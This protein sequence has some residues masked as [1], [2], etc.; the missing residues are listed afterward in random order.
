[1]DRKYVKRGFMLALAAAFVLVAVSLATRPMFDAAQL[2]NADQRQL[3]QDV[4][5]LDGYVFTR[6][7]TSGAEMWSPTQIAKNL[8]GHPHTLE[9]ARR[10]LA[11]ASG[12]VKH[13]LRLGWTLAVFGVFAFWFGMLTMF[14]LGRAAHHVGART[15]GRG[16][17]AGIV[18]VLA[19]LWLPCVPLESARGLIFSIP[20]N[21]IGVIAMLVFAFAAR[22]GSRAS[23]RT[24]RAT[25]TIG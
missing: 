12:E 8:S 20:P 3:E 9:D 22:R 13:G 18:L 21:A 25:A 14:S 17:V 19:G 11:N 6:F 23:I 15:F 5:V 16:V 10:S 4:G 7:L 24:E 2:A 1:M